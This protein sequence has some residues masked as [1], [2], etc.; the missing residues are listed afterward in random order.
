MGEMLAL[1]AATV[2]PPTPPWVAAVLVRRAKLLVEHAN[3][4]LSRQAGLGTAVAEADRLYKTAVEDL[5]RATKLRPPPPRLLLGEALLCRGQLEGRVARK[6]ALADLATASA[7]LPTDARPCMARG[8]LLEGQ[9]SP[10]TRRVMRSMHRVAPCIIAS[11]TASC[12]P[13]PCVTLPCVAPPCVAPRII[14]PYAILDGAGRALRCTGRVP[15][16]KQ[17]HALRLP[18]GGDG[19]DPPQLARRGARRHLLP[20][21]RHTAG[22][23]LPARARAARRL[24]ATA[25]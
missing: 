13:P 10:A 22:P 24:P 4:V 8:M 6:R 21:P 12:V 23:A 5:T 2:K 1:P 17:P 9:V 11:R 15:K 14:A 3:G 16:G 7:L 20:H 18:A 19:T 25:G